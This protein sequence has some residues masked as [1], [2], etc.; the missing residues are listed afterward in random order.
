MELVYN[1]KL[2]L[3]LDN[4]VEYFRNYTREEERLAS[5]VKERDGGFYRMQRYCACIT[6]NLLK[7]PICFALKS[8]FDYIPF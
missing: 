2:T 3:G 1:G 7:S 4:Q 6:N 8:N 5:Q